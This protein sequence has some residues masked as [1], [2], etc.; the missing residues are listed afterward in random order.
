MNAAAPSRSRLARVPAAGVAIPLL[1]AI[2][3]WLP[4]MER[5]PYE[6]AL[7]TLAASAALGLAA[8]FGFGLAL[9]D[10]IRGGLVA[11]ILAAFL[12]YGPTALSFLASEAAT[13]AGLALLAVGAVALARRLPND[14][15]ALLTANRKL[16]LLL[17]PV[18]LGVGGVAFAEQGKLE[19][20]RPSGSVFAP[21][22]GAAAAGGPDVWH[23]V[24][25]RYGNGETL[26]RVYGY[27]NRP[28]LDALRARGFAVEEQAYANYQ[29]TA[30][31][32]A[33]TLNGAYLDRLA[34][35]GPKQHDWVPLYRA[36]GDNGAL[37]FFEAAGYETVFAGTWWTP[38]RRSAIA[39]R[40][41][42]HRAMPELGRRL[43]D[44]SAAGWTLRA[45][46]LPY[47]DARIDQCERERV[48]FER[49]RATAGLDRR[50]Y[51]FAHF[52]VPHPPYVINPD[53]SCRSLAEAEAA[54]RRDNY[55]A[56][57]EYT[58]RE[59]LKLVDAI[60]AGPR[61]AAIVLH[62][63]EGPWPDPHVGDERFIGRDPVRVDWAGLDSGRLREK[64]GIL[65]AV[66][67]AD[68]RAAPA[69]RSPVEIY[70]ALLRAHFG[71]SAP[72]PPRHHYV[73][74]GNSA[75]YDFV[76][77]GDRLR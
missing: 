44:Q 59:T 26:R 76:E 22:A 14:R 67:F 7:P 41:I 54:S 77:V 19:S 49:L 10:R 53:G 27:D 9:R 37:R 2:T 47:G 42:N 6:E 57:L 5:V 70:P 23:I 61:A 45:L 20:A 36:L 73:F 74:R 13:G 12:L 46:G 48:K 25:D 32:V 33:S 65:M 62:A 29:R 8:T 58:N 63:D 24:F 68:G 1:V 55:L 3:L 15:A 72:N 50:K 4:N 43:L 11:G 60:L 18:V 75:L 17:L 52:L 16:N 64:M 69:P 40:N 71:G 39:D 66:R 38:T 31:S 34:G 35:A 30:H 28:F 56:Q 51:V 21:F